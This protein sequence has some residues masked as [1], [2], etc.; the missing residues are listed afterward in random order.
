MDIAA[1]ACF[2]L[3][4]HRRTVEFW[5]HTQIHQLVTSSIHRKGVIHE[6]QTK[7]DSDRAGIIAAGWRRGQRSVSPNR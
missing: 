1:V 7:T 5:A 2:S 6:T 4:A 3:L